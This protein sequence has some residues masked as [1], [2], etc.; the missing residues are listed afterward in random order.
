MNT[1]LKMITSKSRQKFVHSRPIPLEVDSD[2]DFN[3]G[4]FSYEPPKRGRRSKGRSMSPKTSHG[5]EGRTGRGS[6]L[7]GIKAPK[8]NRGKK[9][10]KSSAITYHN[11]LAQYFKD[12]DLHS[13][14]EDEDEDKAN[15][16]ND[17]DDE[18]QGQ[19][20]TAEEDDE[21]PI[22]LKT[23]AALMKPD[24]SNKEATEESVTGMIFKGT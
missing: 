17:T 6:V 10:P 9:A 14:S 19:S 23:W 12:L 2:S 18:L 7:E 13:A 15:D 1:H 16:E 4:S 8:G 3:P 24:N 21:S 5:S 11:P 20:G 22:L